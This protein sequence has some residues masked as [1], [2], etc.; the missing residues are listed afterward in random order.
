MAFAEPCATQASEWSLDDAT[1]Y[2]RLAPDVQSS[3]CAAAALLR[4]S[5][6]EDSELEPELLVRYLSVSRP[7]VQGIISLSSANVDDYFPAVRA[8]IAVGPKAV[9]TL[10]VT[11]KEPTTEL[12]VRRNATRAIQRLYEAEPAGSI[13]DVLIAARTEHG[14]VQRTLEEAAYWL[15]EQCDSASRPL[16]D[17][18]LNAGGLRP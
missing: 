18:A 16:C 1:A 14:V 8:L 3:A 7:G 9:P 2:L 12:G 4:C 13:R 6:A 11:I 10:L 5:E 15:A 17:D